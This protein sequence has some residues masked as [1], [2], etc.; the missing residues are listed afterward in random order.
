ME[1]Q[2]AERMIAEWAAANADAIGIGPNKIRA[3]YIFNPGGFGNLSIRLA[4]GR[5]RLHV[6]LAPPSNAARLRKWAGVSDYL[7]EHYAAPRLVHEI[8]REILPGYPYGLVFEYIEDATPIAEARNP[9]AALTGIMETAAKL[10]RDDRLR[11]MLPKAE[12]RTY[13]EAF[14]D[15]YISRFMDDLEGIQGSRELLRDFVSDETISWFGEEI[16]RL[17]ETVRQTP[18]FLLPAG[19]V[20]HNDLNG[21]NVL[22]CGRDGFRIID[23]DDLSGQG[24][25]AMDYSVLLWPIMHDPSWPIWREKVL[26]VAG[27]AVVERLELY[28]RAKLLDDV[29]DV[30]ADYVEAEQVPEHREEAQRKAKAVHLQ[31]YPQY[32]AKYGVG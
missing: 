10:H 8:D 14:E 3:S 13:A 31:S 30:L 4:D 28:F 6:K 7:A 32:L 20:V 5:T 1:V 24:D 17:R 9:E 12:M 2:L 26:A 23:W 27:A 15:E 22:T 16:R 21:N 19:D 18:A 29:I 11:G 25:A